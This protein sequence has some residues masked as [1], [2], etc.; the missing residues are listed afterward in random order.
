MGSKGFNGPELHHKLN[1]RDG[2]SGNKY[3]SDIRI[4]DPECQDK[5]MYQQVTS[6]M[7]I[8]KLYK[9]ALYKID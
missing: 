7:R 3:P 5:K 9:N 8:R 4:N 6:K 2:I 1:K